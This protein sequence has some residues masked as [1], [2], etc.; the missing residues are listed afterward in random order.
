MKT[1]SY[2]VFK[3]LS[4][5]ITK[6]VDFYFFYGKFLVF[7]ISEDPSLRSGAVTPYGLKQ[8]YMFQN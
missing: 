6:I 8:S 1:D 5:D 3:A 2:T 7:V 4:Y